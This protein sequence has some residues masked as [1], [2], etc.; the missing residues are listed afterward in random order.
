[1][2]DGSVWNNKAWALEHLSRWDEARAAYEKA[3]ELGERQHAP[4]NLEAIR[5][6]V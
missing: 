4:A 5:D 2:S 1:P 3:I 6:K